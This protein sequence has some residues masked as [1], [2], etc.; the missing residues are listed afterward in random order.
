MFNFFFFVHCAGFQARVGTICADTRLCLRHGR[1]GITPS[2]M[3]KATHILNKCCIH[4]LQ[5]SD[6]FAAYKKLCCR[7]FLS[8][9]KHADLIINLFSM[10][11]LIAAA[12]IP[13]TV[14]GIQ[15]LL[16]LPSTPQMRSTGIPE[17]TCVED[18]DYIRTVLMLSEQEHEAERHF[19]QKV[20]KKCLG[21]GWTVQVMWWMH[22]RRKRASWK[23]WN[24]CNTEDDQWIFISCS[25]YVVDTCTLTSH[26][27]TCTEENTLKL[28]TW[29][30]LFILSTLFILRFLCI[31]D[32]MYVPSTYTFSDS[33]LYIV[34]Y[35]YCKHQ[36]AS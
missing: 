18:T 8:L 36:S 11:R 15:F 9:R 23:F 3:A 35:G 7:A 1:R 27:N 5:K 34:T 20:I 30:L 29:N 13:M 19:E 21:L 32:N 6:T 33:F 17:L 28:C 16:S 26:T 4:G 22:L 10:V 2:C 31:H 14:A 25:W 24:I 12:C